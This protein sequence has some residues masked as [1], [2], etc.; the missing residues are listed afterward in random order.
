MFLLCLAVGVAEAAPIPALPANEPDDELLDFLG[1]WQFDEGRWIDPF[2]VP[3]D[4]AAPDLRDPRPNRHDM[5]VD[6]HKP[7][8]EAPPTS[9]T[10]RPR[11]PVRKHTDP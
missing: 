3:D 2:T 5:S 10:H 9:A 6:S 7:A 4:H 11:D 1:S 8:E